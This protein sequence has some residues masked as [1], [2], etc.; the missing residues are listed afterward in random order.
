MN[1]A[2]FKGHSKED[3]SKEAMYKKQSILSFISKKTDKIGTAIYMVT[4]FIPESEPVRIQLRTSALSLMSKTRLLAGNPM[5]SETL[6]ADEILRDVGEILAVVS[7]ASTI[8]LV[9]HM[10]AA[11]LTAEL[12]KNEAELRS[13]YASRMSLSATTPGLSNVVLDQSFFR[14][15]RPVTPTL[16]VTETPEPVAVSAPAPEEENRVL[17]K[18]TQPPALKK[19][20]PAKQ[21]VVGIKIARRNDVLAVI[22]S[23]G[24]ASIKD[25]SLV[26][27][28]MSEKT[29]QRELLALVKEGVLKKEGEKRWSTYK[30]A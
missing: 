28:D 4:D 17:Y 8:G 24:S 9:S 13:L 14:V 11:I 26:V 23:K 18:T 19:E 7:L 6:L 15:E 29:V 12:S 21:S 3:T 25:I 5:E 27:K 1:T 16:P 30:I 2:S 10:N 22:K 20:A